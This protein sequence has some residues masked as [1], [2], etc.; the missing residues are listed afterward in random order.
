MELHLHTCL[1]GWGLVLTISMYTHGWFCDVLLSVR[2]GQMA[3][4]QPMPHYHTRSGIQVATQGRHRYVA[5]PAHGMQ[6]SGAQHAAPDRHAHTLFSVLRMLCLR[7]SRTGMYA[8]VRAPR[9]C[10][11]LTGKGTW[12]EGLRDGTSSPTRQ[13]TSPRRPASPTRTSTITSPTR[14]QRPAVSF[15]SPPG[16]PQVAA[17]PILW[18]ATACHDGMQWLTGCVPTCNDPEFV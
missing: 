7:D 18:H 16:Y 13:P 10:V 14:P 4:M 12:Q 17:Q 6:H 9:S 1:D 15:S 8:F 5:A 11:L 2:L 3:A